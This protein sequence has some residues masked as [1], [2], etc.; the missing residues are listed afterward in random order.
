M[1]I[2]L[3]QRLSRSFY[4]VRDEDKLNALTRL[5]D[6][7]DPALTLVFCHTKRDV[8]DV[9]GSCRRWDIMQAQS[10]AILPSLT[11]TR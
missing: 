10:T 3:S 9:S 4:E 11:E 5:L 8:D 1:P 2:L 7:E 6:V